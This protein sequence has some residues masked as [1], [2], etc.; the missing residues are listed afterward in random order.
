MESIKED[1]VF[2]INNELVYNPNLH[3][4]SA[5]S[6][7]D[8]LSSLAIPASRC[9]NLLLEQH[10][11]VVAQ[12]YML[13]NVWSSRGIV[14]SVNTLYQN[15]FILRSAIKK[16]G[17]SR[18]LIKTIPKRG[19]SIPIDI[20][21]DI[22]TIENIYDEQSHYFKNNNE[23]NSDFTSKNVT[24]NKP[25]IIT[26]NTINTAISESVLN[27][28]VVT[29]TTDTAASSVEWWHAENLKRY[30]YLAL[31]IALFLFSLIF[32]Y[33]AS[34]DKIAVKTFAHFPYL[35]DF[36]QCKVFRNIA[37]TDDSYYLQLISELK[38]RCNSK[39]WWYIT[40]YPPSDRISVLTCTAPLDDDKDISAMCDSNVFINEQ[41]QNKDENN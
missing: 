15:I 24:G 26:T 25:E 14:V 4:L 22:V 32:T 41:K 13:D 19:F 10:G 29:S 28:A 35:R 27:N 8:Q 31:L 20:S 16:F 6:K 18:E 39:E 3:T 23:N 5:L 11:T 21:I 37:K 30:G 12:E 7:D 17:I 36:G 34:K 38:L 2:I 33:S 40:S 9:F 1:K